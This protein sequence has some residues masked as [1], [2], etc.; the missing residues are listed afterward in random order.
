LENNK[1]RKFHAGFFTADK[2]HHCC[3][4][5]QAALK[6]GEKRQNVAVPAIRRG[7]ASPID[8][9]SQNTKRF[10]RRPHATLSEILIS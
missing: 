9:A 10:A 5:F 3:P 1:L 8:G 6:R 4:F 7:F 2:A